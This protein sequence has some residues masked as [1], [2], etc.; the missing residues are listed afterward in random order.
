MHPL[1]RA[2]CAAVWGLPLERVSPSETLG[3]PA[4]APHFSRGLWQQ[5]HQKGE[6]RHPSSDPG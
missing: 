1:T 3:K 6:V 2:G 4:A 5:G